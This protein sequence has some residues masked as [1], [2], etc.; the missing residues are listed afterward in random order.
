MASRPR[1]P[2]STARLIEAAGQAATAL[3]ALMRP[4]TALGGGCD[5]VLEEAP[6]WLDGPARARIEGAAAGLSTRRGCWPAGSRCSARLGGETDPDFVDWLAVDRIEG[7]EFDI[8]LH[9]HWLDPGRPLA[10]DRAGAGAW[11]ARHLRDADRRCGGE[12]A[13]WA[14]AEARTGTRHLDT[15]VER[16]AAKSPFDYASAGRGADRHRSSSAAICPQLAHAYARLIEAS[17]GGDARPV[18][19]DRAAEGGPCPHRRSS[20]PRGTAALRPACR[21]DRHRHAGRHFPR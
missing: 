9:R 16:F 8:G 14:R 4:L 17:Q 19:R 6:D 12:D 2:S 20:R 1:R 18:H 13:G 21:S 11:R 7:R 5:A 15:A 10:V 3:E